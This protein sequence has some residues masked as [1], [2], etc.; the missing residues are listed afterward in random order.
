MSELACGTQKRSTLKSLAVCAGALEYVF[1]E[2]LVQ[3]RLKCSLHCNRKKI[4]DEEKHKERT[5][6]VPKMIRFYDAGTLDDKNCAGL[7]LKE[8][9]DIVKNIH[10]AIIL[11]KMVQ[12][13]K[14][15]RMPQGT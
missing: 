1:Y 15:N 8:F 7:R 13:Q 12:S 6:I 3:I 11:Q 14:P 4:F 2:S 5:I 10:S 9:D